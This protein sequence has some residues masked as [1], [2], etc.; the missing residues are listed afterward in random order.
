MW[1]WDWQEPA[2]YGT[3][4]DYGLIESHR[5][6]LRQL[7]ECNKRKPSVAWLCSILD[8]DRGTMSALPHMRIDVD[9][10]GWLLQE[11]RVIKGE[12]ERG[13]WQLTRGGIAACWAIQQSKFGAE[14]ILVGFDVIKAGIACPVDDAFSP[15]YQAHPGFWGIDGYQAGKTKEGNHDYPAERRLIEL[16]AARRGAVTVRFAEDVWP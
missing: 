8:T 3:R 1:N 7:R 12:G 10:D 14:V 5:K 2:D 13:Y 11:G 6:V 9:Q 4:Y 16:V 15:Q